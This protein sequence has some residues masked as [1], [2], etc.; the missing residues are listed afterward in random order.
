MA[1]GLL[2]EKCGLTE[3]EAYNYIREL[4]R[5]KRMSMKEIAAIISRDLL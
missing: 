1:K 3:H 5:V 4:S 2:M